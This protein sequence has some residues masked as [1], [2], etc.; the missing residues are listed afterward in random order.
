MGTP[1][2]AAIFSVASTM[3]WSL[4]RNKGL[5][6][7]SSA[8]VDCDRTVLRSPQGRALMPP[9]SGLHGMDADALVGQ[10]AEHLALLLAL[11]QAVLVLDRR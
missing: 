9:L 11:G 2:S 5:P 10:E 6:Y 8:G 4:S 7:M 3:A 1:R